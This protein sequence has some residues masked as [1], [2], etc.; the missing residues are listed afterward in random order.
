[1]PYNVSIFYPGAGEQGNKTVLSFEE[2]K[3]HAFKLKE[4]FPNNNIFV[5][6]KYKI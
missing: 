4:N 3:T 5:S 1:M 2:A 6:I